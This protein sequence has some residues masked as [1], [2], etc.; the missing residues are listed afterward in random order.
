M[1]NQN[2]DFLAQTGFHFTPRPKLERKHSA[3]KNIFLLSSKPEIFPCV[4]TI[5]NFI[6]LRSLNPNF[7]LD[8]R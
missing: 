5:E 7:F 1:R 3:T 2:C 8:F 4:A 6:R